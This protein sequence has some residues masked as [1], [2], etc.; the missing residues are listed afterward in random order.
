M[1]SLAAPTVALIAAVLG[2]P[3]KPGLDAAVDAGLLR[4]EQGR[5]RFSHPLLGL[6]ASARVAPSA[7]RA[8]HAR[9][10]A[11]LTDPEQRARHLVLAAAVE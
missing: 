9:L 6:A 5:L 10:A 2:E 7:R 1:A 8:L 3:A 11:A 4:V